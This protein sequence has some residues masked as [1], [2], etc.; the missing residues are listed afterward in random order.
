MRW[1]LW[2]T[3]ATAVLC[4]C[5]ANAQERPDV[6]PG[7]R[8][9]VTAPSCGLRAHEATLE[10]LEGDVLLPSECPIEQLELLEG[11]QPT[12]V[13]KTSGLGLMIGAG[14][15]GVLLGVTEGEAISRLAGGVIGGGVGLALGF[16]MGATE[17]FGAWKE[18]PLRTGEQPGGVWS[19]TP[20]RRPH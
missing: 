8:I 20:P 17:H 12:P 16:L 11:F 5:S 7:D 19:P 1:A 15:G 2:S 4:P 9:R 18:V 3:L 10:S 6:E 13:W 14:V